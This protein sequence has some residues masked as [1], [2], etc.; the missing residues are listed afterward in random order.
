MGEGRRAGVETEESLLFALDK[1][2]AHNV[3]FKFD[4]KTNKWCIEFEV[5]KK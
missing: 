3:V 1:T 2:K 4:P 5:R